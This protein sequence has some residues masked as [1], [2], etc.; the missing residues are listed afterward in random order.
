VKQ[1]KASE[2][3]GVKGELRVDNGEVIPGLNE[4]WTL[5]G[6]K[7]F[8]WIAGFMMF[9]IASELF[10]TNT[11]RA[12]PQLMAIWVCTTFGLAAGRRMFPDEE[13][14]VRNAALT[15][16]GI[17][18]PGIPTPASLQPY[19]SGAPLRE[20]DESSL[21]REL[22]LDLVLTTTEDGADKYTD[23]ELSSA[24]FAPSQKG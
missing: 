18:P 9:I 6:A 22:Q 15:A 2:R 21:F 14:G 7:L 8:E 16:L 5:G 17:S 4:E 13:R 20:L 10:F 12:M 19:W 11:G 3:L 1:S 23:E 24:S